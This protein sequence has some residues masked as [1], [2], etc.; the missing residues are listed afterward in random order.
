MGPSRRVVLFDTIAD[1]P[2]P[3]VRSVLAHEFGHLE[4]HHIPKGIGWS[5]L[6]LVPTALI[7]A[8][9][10]R[11][12]GGMYDPAAVPLALLVFVGLQILATPINSA[13]T[14]RYEAE[15]D[16]TALQT[17]RDPAAMR[18]LHKHFVSKALADPDPPGWW[19]AIFDNHP[20]GLQRIEMA[21]AW[22]K[23]HRR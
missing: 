12:R 8:L 1:F 23:L 10:T 3:E 13:A 14:R 5:A 18:A 6:L 19:H 7:V 20:S 11:R 16:W 4:H 15:A 2:R 21:D 9:L 22:A 17:T